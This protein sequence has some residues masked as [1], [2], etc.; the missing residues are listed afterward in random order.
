MEKSESFISDYRNIGP[1]FKV[2]LSTPVPPLLFVLEH[3]LN[4]A[5]A[6]F[7]SEKTIK[8]TLSLIFLNVH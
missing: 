5:D 7:D 3:N 8:E 2:S 4:Y 6:V 1:P